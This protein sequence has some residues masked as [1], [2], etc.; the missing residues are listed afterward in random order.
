[1]GHV[2]RGGD[3]GCD[4]LDL[5]GRNDGELKKEKLIMLNFI[6]NESRCTRC[7]T[8]AQDCPVRIIQ[9]VGREIPRIQPEAESQCLQC[10]HCLAICPTGAL[11]ILGR[12]PEDSLRVTP[13]Q[14][15][16]GEQMI[17]LVRSRRSIRR[18]KD[19]NVAPV[20]IGKMLGAL[21]NS[22]TAVNR[23]ELTFT[24][25]G[26]KDR[27]QKIREKVLATVAEALKS[28][29]I[30]GQVAYLQAAVPA[31]YEHQA[32]IIFRGAPHALIISA[33]LDAPCPQEDISL[34]LAYFELMAQSH[35]LGTVWWGMLSILLSTLPELRPLFEIPEK[36][37]YYAMLFGVPGVRYPRCVQRDDGARVKT[38]RL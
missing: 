38:L 8:C 15:P 22:P 30:P 37:R 3:G 36:H 12:N 20:L 32:D 31:Y 25:I 34:A 19:E 14:L 16:T 5:S 1:M 17:N 28:G 10:Q 26:D 21:A 27:M 11:S 18:Y 24:V 4:Q 35:G 7:G 33:P 9:Q 13:E 2:S 29:R 23:R 6:I